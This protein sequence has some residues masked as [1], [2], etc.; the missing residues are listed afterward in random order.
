MS[1]VG[2]DRRDLED[3]DVGAAATLDEVAE[4][5]QVADDVRG[6]VAFF[7]AVRTRKSVTEPG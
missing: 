7:D 4:D 2:I 3:L 6:G 1:A 5:Q